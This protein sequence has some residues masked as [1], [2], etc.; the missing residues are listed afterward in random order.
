M[1]FSIKMELYLSPLLLGQVTG[2]L[3]LSFFI[4]KMGA[5]V[6]YGTWG[7]CQAPVSYHLGSSARCQEHCMDSINVTSCH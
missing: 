2:P 6:E 1:D 7:R 4:S 3:S 5:L